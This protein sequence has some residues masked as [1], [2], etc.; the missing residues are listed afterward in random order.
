MPPYNRQTIRSNV[1]HVRLLLLSVSLL[2]EQAGL[3]RAVTYLLARYR[4]VSRSTHLDGFPHRSLYRATQSGLRHRHTQH[5]TEFGL[6]GVAY[7]GCVQHRNQD[8]HTHGKGIACC[9]RWA[10]PVGRRTQV[11]MRQSLPGCWEFS[12]GCGVSLRTICDSCV[13]MYQYTVYIQRER[14]TNVLRSS[15]VLRNWQ[16]KVCCAW[17][18]IRRE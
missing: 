11:P 8:T 3:V 16:W 7:L 13:W 17:L 15:S 10:R 2:S 18:L 14:P 12:E 9:L 5:E 6:P 4:T 1:N